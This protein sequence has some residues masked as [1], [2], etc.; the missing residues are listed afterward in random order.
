MAGTRVWARVFRGLRFFPPATAEGPAGWP[1]DLA[2][3]PRPTHLPRYQHS[4]ASCFTAQPLLL[5]LATMSKQP[6]S[7]PHPISCRPV[8]PFTQP[9]VVAAQPHPSSPPSPQPCLSFP[10]GVDLL[11][12]LL[13]LDP[14]YRPSAFN[15]LGH[16]YF[17][18][19]GEILKH[20]P[21]LNC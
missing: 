6:T 5:S 3:D 12:S 21:Q 2:P 7:C 15:S 9:L 11:R 1:F 8:R 16:N 13:S 14:V 4:A 19:I 20:P 10:A 17:N 18:D